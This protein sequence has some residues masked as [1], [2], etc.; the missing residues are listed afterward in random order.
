[1]NLTNIDSYAE[2]LN[3]AGKCLD[4]EICSLIIDKKLSGIVN[5]KGKNFV[6]SASEFY[7]ESFTSIDYDRL[8]ISTYCNFQKREY[9]YGFKSLSLLNKFRLRNYIKN[10]TIAKDY[11]SSY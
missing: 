2:L 10:G 5:L 6:H 4:D 11:Y 7:W 8:T 3:Q 1:M 9:T